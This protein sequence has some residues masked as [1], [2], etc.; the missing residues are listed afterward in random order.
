MGK[1][2][3]RCIRIQRGREAKTFW[4]R[5]PDPEA[6]AVDA[7]HQKWP[8]KGLY[9]YPPWETDPT[10]STPIRRAEDSGSDSG[11]TLLANAILVPYDNEMDNSS[12]SVFSVNKNDKVGRLEVIREIRKSKGISEEMI[13]FLEGSHRK[14]TIRT[15]NSAWLVWRD[16]CLQQ[17]PR[18][19]PLEYNF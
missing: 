2:V 12:P 17:N 6:A 7:F 14:G 3:D 5:F 15:Y 4:S 1:T 16:W 13:N 18:V 9:L 10:S 11:D 19:S 8:K